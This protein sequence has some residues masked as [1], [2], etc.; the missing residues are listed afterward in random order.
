MHKFRVDRHDRIIEA[1]EQAAY[2]F[3]DDLE[4]ETIP[5]PDASPA[6][7]AALQDLVTVTETTIQVPG[8]EA[9]ERAAKWR[10]ARLDRLAAE[11]EENAQMHWFAANAETAEIIA[12]EDKSKIKR[13]QVS[14]KAST[15]KIPASTY[16]K[17]KV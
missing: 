5:K 2:R 7:Y 11:A 3:A 9:M 14:R 15:K 10:Q 13:T 17:W 12:L 6:S 16:W 8:S 4:R 1:L